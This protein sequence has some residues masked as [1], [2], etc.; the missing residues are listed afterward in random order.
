[1]GGLEDMILYYLLTIW[2]S[3]ITKSRKSTN[4][5]YKISRRFFSL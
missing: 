4:L 1:M 5:E 2:R 3:A